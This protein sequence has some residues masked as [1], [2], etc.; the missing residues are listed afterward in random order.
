MNA[1]INNHLFGIF[2]TLASYTGLFYLRG[3]LRKRWIN[4]LLLS[5]VVLILFLH[6]TGISYEQYMKGG[7]VIH[8]LLGPV[9]VVLAVPLYRQRALLGVYKYAI[10]AGILSGVA[11][12][13]L[14][15]SLLSRLMGLNMLLER[16][17]AGH[18]I[19]T[20][21]GI[22]VGRILGATQGITIVSIMITGILGAAVAPSLL[23]L[24][25]VS[26]P[27]AK[28]L[29]MGTSSHALGTSKALEMG[30]TEAAMSSLAMGVAGLTTVLAA[31]ALQAAGWY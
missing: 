21:I 29:A 20:P 28:G 18:S 11:A 14:S 7:S 17:L 3:R 31:C 5:I 30:E 25:R 27:V 12:A 10:V 24:L 15:V 9:T 6:G 1:I 2:I 4:P 19:T 8:A 13:L 26:H 16:S 22:A 23:K